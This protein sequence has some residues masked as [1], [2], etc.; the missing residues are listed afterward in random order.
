MRGTYELRLRVVLEL[1]FVLFAVGLIVLVSLF[2]HC[3]E[4]ASTSHREGSGVEGSS[5]RLLPR[6]GRCSR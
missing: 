3:A 6:T 1:F 4:C 2:Y 5:E